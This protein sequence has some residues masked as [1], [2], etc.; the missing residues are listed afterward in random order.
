MADRYFLTVKKGLNCANIIKI[1]KFNVL[2]KVYKYTYILLTMHTELYNYT[3][4]KVKIQN[5]WYIK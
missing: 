2:I 3:N 1:N 4:E 5:K